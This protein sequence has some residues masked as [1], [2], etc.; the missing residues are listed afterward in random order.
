MR[1][2][3]NT[4]SY[5]LK[6]VGEVKLSKNSKVQGIKLS[7]N[8]SGR[9]LVSLSPLI[10]FKEAMKFVHKKKDWIVEHLRK[11]EDE[12]K[13]LKTT[14]TENTKFETKNH[15]LR[16]NRKP[17]ENVS[18]IISENELKFNIPPQYDFGSDFIQDAIRHGI[19][20]TL[21][22]EAKD[23][24]PGRLKLLADKF[25]FKFNQLR[26]K[27]TISRWGSCSGKNNI[28]LSVHL[29]RLP[30]QLIDSVL[31]HELV[32]TVVKNHGKNFWDL[33]LKVN[34]NA[35]LHARELNQYSLRE[36]KS[37]FR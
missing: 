27:N 18:F 26:I 17:G 11:I 8:S 20:E 12:N 24:L 30:D 25:G 7:V 9:I 6:G 19:V 13:N 28:N 34:P 2:K 14:F 35:K 36:Y 33:L 1:R 4:R 29:M 32:H 15:V 37:R 3:S 23:Y 21:R 16:F 31:L 10:P 5:Q 22:M